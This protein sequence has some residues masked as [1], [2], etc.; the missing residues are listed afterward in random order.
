[1]VHAPALAAASDIDKS[2]LLA[3][4]KDDGPSKT[5]DISQRLNVKKGYANVYRSRL[6]EADLIDVPGRGYVDCAPLSA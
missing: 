2:Y 3:M 5:S 4:A 1:M 6:I